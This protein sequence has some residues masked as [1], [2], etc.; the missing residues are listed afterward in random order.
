MGVAYRSCTAVGNQYLCAM[1]VCVCVCGVYAYV[2]ACGVY[3]CVFAVLCVC[4]C[5]VM[6]CAIPALF[7]G[8]CIG[9]KALY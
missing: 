2:H 8:L 7:Y 1:C 3:V 6:Q 9:G 5:G 4:A